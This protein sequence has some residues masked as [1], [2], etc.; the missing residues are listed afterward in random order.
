[1]KATRKPAKG[2]L[3]NALF[4]QA[5]A[6]DLP[7]ELDGIANEIH[8]QFPWGSLLRAVATADPAVFRALR[9]IAA[10]D[11]LLEIIVGI[12][13]E[14]DRA[15]ISRLGIPVLTREYIAGTLAA[16]FSTA[17]FEF[18]ADR[19]LDRAEWLRLETTWARKLSP[20]V[21]RSVM[22]FLLKA[23]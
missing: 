11:C 19:T 15:E 23:S 12:D 4:V 8:I 10:P 6:E 7:I 1:M 13:P 2:G 18:I 9:R 17:G 5:A 20:N 3:P 14:R 21:E 22:M 16:K